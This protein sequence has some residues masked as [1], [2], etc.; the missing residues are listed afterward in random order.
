MRGD[1]FPLGQLG[2]A[3]AFGEHLR[4]EPLRF[5]D[6]LDLE[7]RRVGRILQPAQAIR[8][9]IQPSQH[10]RRREGFSSA[11]DERDDDAGEA[12]DADNEGHEHHQVLQ[13]SCIH[14]Y[15]G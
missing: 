1:R 7:R 8:D 14:D 3:V 5:G 10:L 15:S 12:S 11:F 4:G 9:L 13:K 6:P 2:R